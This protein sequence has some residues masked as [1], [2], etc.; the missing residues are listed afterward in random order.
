MSG[1]RVNIEMLRRFERGLDPRSPEKSTVP[2]KVLG[3]GEIS[4]VFEI[5]KG[6]ELSLAYKRLPMFKNQTEVDEYKELYTQ[7]LD[8]LQNRVGLNLIPSE[9]LDFEDDKTGRNIV[10]IVQEKINSGNICHRIIHRLDPDSII[11]LVVAVLKETRKV[12]DFNKAY[13]GTL[14]MGFDGQISNWAISNFNPSKP[15]TDN[16]NLV[17]LDTSTPMMQKNGLEQLN[18]ELFLRCAPSFLVWIIRRLFLEDV[19]TRYYSFRKVVMDLIANFYKEQRPDLI[20][21]LTKIVN[22]LCMED[23]R[24]G[25]IELITEKEIKSY[26]SNDALIWRFYLSARKI[27]RALHHLLGRDYPYILPGKTKR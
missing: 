6:E 14:E 1:Y 23:T 20:P 4:T 21:S 24:V 25:S 9:I 27:D 13:E 11:Q 8:I 12:F 22:K 16:L 26:Y 15:L 10:Y 19:M 7:Y 2:A 3:Y 17:Y 5:G 18:P